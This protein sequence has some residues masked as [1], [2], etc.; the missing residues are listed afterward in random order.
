MNINQINKYKIYVEGGEYINP[1]IEKLADKYSQQEQQSISD[2]DVLFLSTR[3]NT[4]YKN[5]IAYKCI[6]DYGKLPKKTTNIKTLLYK[7]VWTKHSD[8]FKAG[9]VVLFAHNKYDVS[10]RKTYLFIETIQTRDGYDLSIIQYCPS[11]IRW[12]DISGIIRE[13]PF[14][15]SSS[16]PSNFGIE[17]DKILIMPNERRHILIPKN[18]YTS[19]I[20]KEQRF[21][22]DNRAWKVS[23]VDGLQDGIITLVLNEDGIDASV[24]N[25]N[26]RIANYV[27]NIFAIHII[28]GNIISINAGQTRQLTTEVLKNGE[29]ANGYD[30]LW[31]SSDTNIVT[32][33][34]NGL[35]TTIANGSAIITATMKDNPSITDT[36]NVNVQFLTT[37]NIAVI[38]N[39]SDVI[40]IGDESHYTVTVINNGV[41]DN[42]KQVQ[43]YLFSNDGESPTTLAS[44]V[45]N[46]YSQCTIKANNVGSIKLKCV[47]IGYPSSTYTKDIVI[48]HLY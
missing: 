21:I 9:D 3:A 13:V 41:I 31:S 35:M 7:E 20:K 36:I 4:I 15:I 25:I 6:V 23:V 17:D 46:Q 19:Q 42:T 30:I 22:F 1:Q 39:G 44:F 27:Q 33:D 34:E 43:W 47:V 14:C 37:N 45:T 16:T 12:I 24:D 40:T 38:I 28:G 2:L 8:D 29:I 10:E 32:I 48:R 18:E 11:S 26:E 5:N